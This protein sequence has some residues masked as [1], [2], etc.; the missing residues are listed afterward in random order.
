MCWAMASDPATS[1][2]VTMAI[3]FI[4]NLLVLLWYSFRFFFRGLFGHA[5]CAFYG[6][7]F[8]VKPAGLFQL[9]CRPGKASEIDITPRPGRGVGRRTNGLLKQINSS[10][11]IVL[12]DGYPGQ[13]V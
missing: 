6:E 10:I 13:P 11:R 1:P 9:P 8:L 2:A 3:N 4:S 7:R 5:G 12:K